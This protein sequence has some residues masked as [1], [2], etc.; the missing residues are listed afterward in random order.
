[1]FEDEFFYIAKTRKPEIFYRTEKVVVF[2]GVEDFIAWVIRNMRRIIGFNSPAQKFF[3]KD[4][5]GKTKFCYMLETFVVR[6]PVKL[7]LANFFDYL[8]KA[9]LRILIVGGVESLRDKQLI[10]VFIQGGLGQRLTEREAP[11]LVHLIDL[12]IENEKSTPT[13]MVVQNEQD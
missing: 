10:E 13:D 2:K 8:M 6:R 4:M 7:T 12:L 11:P 5:N 1:L 9:R 3:Y